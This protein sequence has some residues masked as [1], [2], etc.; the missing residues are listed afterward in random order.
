MSG[1]QPIYCKLEIQYD[2]SVT[3]SCQVFPYRHLITVA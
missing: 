1:F 3:F 2:I